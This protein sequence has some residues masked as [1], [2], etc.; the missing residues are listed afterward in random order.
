MPLLPET[1]YY[2]YYY[3]Y[4]YCLSCVQSVLKFGDWFAAAWATEEEKQMVFAVK[5]PAHNNLANCSFRL[6]T[7]PHVQPSALTLPLPSALCT[8]GRGEVQPPPSPSALSPPSP[9]ALSPPSPSAL[10]P[11]ARCRT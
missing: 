5:L 9:S 8:P 7:H 2:Y 6:G 1:Y 10:S 4:Y 3:Y 11:C